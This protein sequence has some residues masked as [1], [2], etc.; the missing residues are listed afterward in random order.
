MSEN[1]TIVDIVFSALD[2]ASV[3]TVGP[4]IVFGKIYDKIG[5]NAIKEVYFVICL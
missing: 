5:F 3:R 4:E 1:D 2:S